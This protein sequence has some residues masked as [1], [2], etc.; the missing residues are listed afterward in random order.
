MIEEVNEEIKQLY[1]LD[2]NWDY[3]ISDLSKTAI[4]KEIS[5]Q[6]FMSGFDIDKLRDI[7]VKQLVPKVSMIAY[8]TNIKEWQIDNWKKIFNDELSVISINEEI[9]HL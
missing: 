8:R 5:F 9:I 4:G 7:S 3:I 2:S 1:S 6:K